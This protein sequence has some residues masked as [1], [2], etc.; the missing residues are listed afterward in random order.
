MT[1]NRELER[2]TTEAE[3]ALNSLRETTQRELSVLSE[4]HDRLSTS[5]AE[6][7]LALDA[8]AKRKASFSPRERRRI[9]FLSA[10]NA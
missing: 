7:H 9:G 8:A 2:G 1:T 4:K 3:S 5:N 10:A 6:E